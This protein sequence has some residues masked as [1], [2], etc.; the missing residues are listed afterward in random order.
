[1]AE[2][3]KPREV[4]D[5]WFGSGTDAVGVA[6][7]QAALWWSGETA[8]D[9]LIRERF[10]G[11]H[12]AA[13]AGELD[14]WAA[15]PAGRLALIILLDQFSRN[16]HRGAAAAFAQDGRAQ[17]LAREGLERG[18]DRNLPRIRRVFFYMPF[19]HAE[20]LALQ[21]LSVEC[22]LGLRNGAPAAQRATFDYFLD[23]AW[24]HY[25]VIAK[26]GRFPHRNAV[27]GRETTPQEA[28]FLQEKPGGF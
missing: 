11:L 22:F 25:D 16:I 13:A 12:A 4:I 6:K 21:R 3:P 20:D 8:T 26:F 17:V 24:R 23:F 5:F 7:R 2:T 28:A 14:A 1:M 10:G 15:T 9:A 19:E 27:L 18:A